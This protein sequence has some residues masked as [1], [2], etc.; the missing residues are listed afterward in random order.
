MEWG[1]G[2]SGFP[3]EKLNLSLGIVQWVAGLCV[4]VLAIL[5]YK[6]E[7]K[8]SVLAFIL[9]AITL[10]SIFMIH[11]KSSFIWAKLPFL[12]YL[13]FPWRFLAIS[14]FLLCILV[15]IAVYFVGRFK[16]VL[17]IA[18]VIV[19]FALTISFFVPKSWLNINDADKFSGAS[20]EK[21]L[22]ISIFDYLPIYATLPP[23]QKAPLIPEVLDGNVQFL[24][25]KKGSDYQE[26]T[27]EASK[28]SLIRV[29]LFDFPG[30]EVKIDG[31]ITPHVNNDCRGEEY[32]LGLITFSVPS[33]QHKIEVRLENTP[34]RR[35]GN[36]LT[37]ISLGSIA[38]ILLKLKRK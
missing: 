5:K 28:N 30:M 6:K 15:G 31:K 10:F 4:P 2:S 13:Q 8:I 19:S 1:Y 24:N 7:K 14:I 16:Y 21:Q 20:W 22:T 37:L 12:W 36:I 26:G 27:V 29:P 34:V 35:I 33:G 25:Y 38:I 23:V 32:C 11:M 17:G 18:L 3:N 9:S